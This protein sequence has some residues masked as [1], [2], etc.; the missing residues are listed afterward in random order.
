M[1]N[2]YYQKGDVTITITSQEGDKVGYSK[3]KT[4]KR[5]G[6]SFL[7]NVIEGTHYMKASGLKTWYFCGNYPTLD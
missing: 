2:D 7:I 6:M 3:V 1:I 5:N 4:I